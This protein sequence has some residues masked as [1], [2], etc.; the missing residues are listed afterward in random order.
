MLTN[1]VRELISDLSQIARKH[2]GRDLTKS[3]IVHEFMSEACVLIDKDPKLDFVARHLHQAIEITAGMPQTVDVV[4]EPVNLL[5]QNIEA[6]E[7]LTQNLTN[8]VDEA[9]EHLD[10]RDIA[11]RLIGVLQTVL[12]PD[13]NPIPSEHQRAY[14]LTKQVLSALGEARRAEEMAREMDE[15]GLP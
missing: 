5:E 7:R 8:A 12:H 11:K 13:D 15:A 4:A 9:G 6:R 1:Q 3:A 14:Q 10:P 2:V